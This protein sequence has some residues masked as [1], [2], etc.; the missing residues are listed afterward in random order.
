MVKVKVYVFE[1]P[2]I[3]TFTTGRSDQMTGI[4][5]MGTLDAIDRMKG[6][7]LMD[8]ALEVNENEL[9]GS[10]LYTITK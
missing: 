2:D 10:G 3:K 1:L 5:R 8:T 4:V 6:K 7:P 9:D